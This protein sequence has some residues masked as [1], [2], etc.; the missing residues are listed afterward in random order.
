MSSRLL[1]IALHDVAPANFEACRVLRRLVRERLPAAPVTLLVVPAWHDATPTA[2]VAYRQWLNDCI[3]QGDETALHGYTHRDDAPPSSSL[4]D[5]LRRRIYT[6]GEGEFAA[7]GRE[8]AR[9]R[10][11]R[12]AAWCRSLGLDIAGFIAPAWLMSA[13]A[14]AA[15]RDCGFAY[16]TTLGGIHALRTNR[17]VAAPTLTWSTRSRWRRIASRGWNGAL[18]RTTRSVSVLRIG[19]HPADAHHPE[20]V[21]QIGRLLPLV[22]RGR[23]V[24][25]KC[26]AVKA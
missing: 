24:V 21:D 26:E 9:E 11:M 22:A 23:L 1:C 3:A 19:L 13:G 4:R 10:M 6:A 5:A 20:I 8:D 2:P 14:W 16:T 25:T 18:A 7:L 17:R 15:A 12:G